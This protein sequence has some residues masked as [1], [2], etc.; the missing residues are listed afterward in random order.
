MSM[1]W[2]VCFMLGILTFGM[3]L[4]LEWCRM[5]SKRVVRLQKQVYKNSPLSD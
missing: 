3:F 1:L 4:A 5:L 2:C